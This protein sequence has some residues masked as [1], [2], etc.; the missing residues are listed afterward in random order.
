MGDIIDA[1][2]RTKL[3]HVLDDA[4]RCCSDASSEVVVL[5][6]R[7]DSIQGKVAQLNFNVHGLDTRHVI[8]NHRYSQ[9][10]FTAIETCP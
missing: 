7:G 1:L 5:R 10:T 2:S 8:I 4:R 3:D 9:F 6:A